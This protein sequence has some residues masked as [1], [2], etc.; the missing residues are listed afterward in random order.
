MH[1]PPSPSQLTLQA[2][3]EQLQHCDLVGDGDTGVG[4]GGPEA[5]DGGDLR[6]WTQGT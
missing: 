3:G 4:V 1:T 5:L 2:V 6:L